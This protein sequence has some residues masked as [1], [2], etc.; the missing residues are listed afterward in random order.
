MRR[1]VRWTMVPL[2]LAG[3]M[4]LLAWQYVHVEIPPPESI[5]LADAGTTVPMLDVGGRAAVEA[6]INGQGPYLFLFDT[7]ASATVLS[8]ELI[9]EL[10]LPAASGLAGA[11]LVRMDEVRLGGA[12]LTGVTAAR[13]SLLGGLPS[14]RPP[15]GV[16]SA[17]GFPDCLVILDYPA[18]QVTIRRGA[19]PAADEARVFQYAAEDIL[20][21]VPVRIAGHE[22]RVHVDS[23]APGGLTLPLRYES[24]VPLADAPMQIGLARTNAGEFPVFRA[25]VKSAVTLGEYSLDLA[26][27]QF[28]DLHPGPAAP[29]GTIGSRILGQ[30]VVTLDAKNHRVRFER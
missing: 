28:S 26:E 10:K 23:G 6:R 16:L 3:L 20:P 22:Y 15:R 8:P 11:A 2:M 14:D 24:E 30:F 27:I 18:R 9:Q 17:S 4:A 25:V 12:T 5:T 19:L 21:R 1:T 13:I 29:A 7:G